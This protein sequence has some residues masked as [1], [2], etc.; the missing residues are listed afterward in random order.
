MQYFLSKHLLIPRQIKCSNL[1]HSS[2][3]VTFNPGCTSAQREHLNQ[4][5][6]RFGNFIG[7]QGI[8]WGVASVLLQ[9]AVWF[10]FTHYPGGSSVNI[11]K[12]YQG[13]GPDNY[14]QT[15]NWCWWWTTERN[16][17]Q[18]VFQHK[19]HLEMK[20][21]FIISVSSSL[22]FLQPLSQVVFPFSANKGACMADC[23]E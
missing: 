5:S 20:I 18:W 4:S 9:N 13:K 3:S 16:T 10:C 8:V 12:R 6:Q 22:L 2:V 21:Y 17:F 19:N 1:V 11:H 15:N 14:K 23:E 7:Y